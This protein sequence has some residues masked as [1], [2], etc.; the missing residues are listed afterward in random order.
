MR[1]ATI[2]SADRICG[3]VF[4]LLGSGPVALGE[5]IDWHRD[6]KSG[7][8]WN[9]EQCFLDVGHGHHEAG[10]D[11][12]VPWELSR[13]YHLVLLAQA[14]LLTG[15]S[16]YAQECLS[17]LTSWIAT[18]PTGRGVN[19]SCPM[20]VAIRAVNWLWALAL[21][22]ESPLITT[23]WFTGVLGSLV[24]HGRFLIDNLEVRDDNVTTNHYLADLV[25]LLYLGLCLKDVR[26]AEE[27]TAFAVRALV[28][29]MDRQVLADGVHYES[30]L[31]YHRLVTEMF[32]SSALLCRCHGVGLP[33][34]FHDRLA[35]M[36]EFVA[37]YTKPN[38][39]A[40]QIGDGD[41]GRLHILTGYDHADVR[42]HRHLLAVGA[43]LFD[44]AEW[45]AESGPAWVE[46]VWFGG[47]RDAG[48]PREEVLEERG[49]AAFPAG[50]FYILR[51]ARDYVL[52][53][54]NPP[55]TQG[56]GT[57]KHN[58]LL[59]LEM[60]LGGED[61]L[62]DSGCFLYTSDPQSY[63]RFRST[64]FH[65]TVRVDQAEQNRFIPGKSFCLHP[66]SRLS[67]V[68]WDIGGPVEQAA[69]DHDGYERFPH[70]VRHRR[71]VRA[72]WLNRSWRVMD[73]LFS[74]MAGS[75]PHCLEWTLTFSPQCSFRRMETGWSVITP[76]QQFWL[77]GP[78]V[79]A[80]GK[81]VAI[82]PWLDEQAIAEQYGRVRTASCLRWSWEGSLPVEG[83]FT[84]SCAGSK[85]GSV[86]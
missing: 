8:R 17:Q 41:N 57:H 63:D 6:F 68:Q 40:P 58:D 33:A 14:T 52:F 46:G 71:Q 11:I 30:S 67:P 54:C 37:G 13:G 51:K 47:I 69:A 39:L 23:D 15:D 20:D 78:R 72:D 59:S 21:L 44:R 66:D 84:I 56:V 24:A 65:S 75:H 55:G 18:N 12:K 43:V 73:D 49:S 76:R 77:D 31:S 45:W 79:S 32:L 74:P 34:T 19:W 7:Y 29:E 50:G 62:V 2:A 86:Q 53:N 82:S 64:L 61:I 27:W 70:P 4:D 26:D 16:K 48:R 35:K 83:V 60:Q 25:G 5:T 3:H 85:S 1:E 81:S 10:V 22:A 36:C 38:G 80:N 28:G 42:D 9:P